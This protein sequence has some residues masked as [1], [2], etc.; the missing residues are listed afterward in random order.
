MT[1]S[2][3]SEPTT[4]TPTDGS[5]HTLRRLYHHVIH[6]GK[7]RERDRALIDAE[8][9]LANIGRAICELE[10]RQRHENQEQ[11]HD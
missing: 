8:P 10:A 5:L 11:A 3:K 1:G 7:T 4:L 2:Y 9:T 6:G